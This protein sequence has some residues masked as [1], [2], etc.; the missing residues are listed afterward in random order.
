MGYAETSTGLEDAVEFEN[1]KV[2][3]L[4]SLIPGGFKYHFD[5]ADSIND[6]G[7]I[8]V[9]GMNGNSSQLFLLTP[10]YAG[11]GTAAEAA[12][13][14]SVSAAAAAPTSAPVPEPEFL[15]VPALAILS[16]RFRRRTRR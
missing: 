6:V 9:Q 13:S 10:D 8:L 4:N 16:A 11:A 5:S 15:V 12:D 14:F 1:G 7:Q 2:T 3:D